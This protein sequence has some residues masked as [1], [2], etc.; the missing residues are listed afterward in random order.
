MAEGTGASTGPAKD[1]VPTTGH[2]WDGIQEYDNPLPS[3][4]RWTFYVCVV[5][6]VG[7]WIAMPAWPT[8]TGYTKGMLEYSRRASVADELKQARASQAGFLKRVGESSL[9]DIRKDAE[10][11]Q[12]AI[13]GGR[14]AYLVNCSQC[15]GT[16]A[17]GA[18]GYPNL[19]DDDWMWG[20][21]LSAVHATIRFGVRSAHDDTR[22]SAMPAFV[23][24]EMLTASQ[25]E[26]VAAFA[27]SLSGRDANVEAAA[28]GKP[29][30]KEHCASCHREKGDGNREFGA[31]NLT[32]DIW[33]FGGDWTDIV[34]TVA[35]S[36]RG[37]MPAW[38]GRLSPETLK[39]LAVYVHSL[40]GGE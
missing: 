35:N 19:N 22:D 23:K 18:K 5:F 38:E 25:A 12:F 39:M 27:L 6:S 33:V 26:D 28:R 7:Y 2:E 40:G 24:D 10:L 30:F 8:L 9:A 31:P 29:L 14:S 15:H 16:G 11:L 4:W 21:S 13:R 17:A 3:W 32:D 37:V 1:P 36:R 34:D 20:G